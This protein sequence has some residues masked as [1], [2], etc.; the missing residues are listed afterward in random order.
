MEIQG[1]PRGEGRR[2][3]F[4]VSRFNSLVTE[5]LLQ[6]AL[7]CAGQ[8][9]VDADDMTVVRV[10]GAWELAGA[11]A[12]LAD[13]GRYDAIVALGCVVRGETPHFDFVAGEASRG[14]GAIAH[15]GGTPVGFGLLTTNTVEQA[16][17]RASP[18]GGNK[19]WEAA[20]SALVMA[21]LY[22]AIG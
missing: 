22:D 14:L 9:G 15:S 19:G 16:I 6:G 3:A 5:Q 2:I 13:S 21:S 12:R 7:D 1:T 10:P 8:H 4:V 17:E 20:L 11:A 18:D